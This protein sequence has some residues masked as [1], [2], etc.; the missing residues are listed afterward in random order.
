MYV[1]RCLS[2]SIY[3]MCIHEYVY[4]DIYGSLVVVAHLGLLKTVISSCVTFAN[5]AYLLYT[6]LANPSNSSKVSPLLFHQSIV[7]KFEILVSITCCFRNSYIGLVLRSLF[8]LFHLWC[9]FMYMFSTDSG[10]HRLLSLGR[11]AVKKLNH[12]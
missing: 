5:L 2:L 6:S 4:I 10:T 8:L 12:N 1:D 11:V 3:I 9:F 7:N